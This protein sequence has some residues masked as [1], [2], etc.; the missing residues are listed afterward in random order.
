M[1]RDRSPESHTAKGT[2]GN[3][4]RG[5]PESAAALCLLLG[6]VPLAAAGTV[7]MNAQDGQKYV[8]IP[9]GTFRM[10]CSEGDHVCSDNEQPAH[11]VTISKGFSMGQTLVTV[12]AYKRYADAA[13]KAMPPE[14]KLLD[15]DLNEGWRQDQ[16]PI[17]NVTWKEANAY[18]QWAGGR[19]PTEAEWEYAARAGSRTSRYGPL[20]EIAWYADNSG[21]A[22]LDSDRILRKEHADYA[23]QLSENGNGPHDVEQKRANG[24]GLYDMLGNVW[25]WIGD[26]YDQNYYQRSSPRDPSGPTSGQFR[27]LRGGSWSYVSWNVR[28]S[29]RVRLRPGIRVGNGGFRCVMDLP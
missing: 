4:M 11:S 10:G 14:A 15:H 18:C 5:L 7:R 26:W 1:A 22:R 23:R 17:V 19:L 25:E 2:A 3:E 13:G 12:A 27:V 21:I 16:Q 20:D 9:A 8:S 6:A 24:F 29:V 28:T